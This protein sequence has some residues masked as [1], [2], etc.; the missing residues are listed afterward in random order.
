MYSL[1]YWKLKLFIY[2]NNIPIASIGSIIK[3]TIAQSSR[4]NKGIRK[5]K[6]ARISID[7]TPI[8]INI[9]KR[10]SP[11]RY[12]FF[13][14]LKNDLNNKEREKSSKKAL[15]SL[16]KNFRR[17]KGASRNQNRTKVSGKIAY[18]PIGSRER[19]KRPS[20]S[21]GSWDQEYKYF[22]AKLIVCIQNA[23][24]ITKVRHLKR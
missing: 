21:I 2:K 20:S 24:F 4:S 18:S 14:G 6:L 10:T 17:L 9:E 22:Y 3:S 19:C 11:S 12:S 16:P 1:L 23:R 7:F 15:F 13:S 8:P 5:R